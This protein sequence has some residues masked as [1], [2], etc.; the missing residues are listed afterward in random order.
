MH[1]PIML[2]IFPWECFYCA[3]MNSLLAL[4]ENELRMVCTIKQAD[5][6]RWPYWSESQQQQQPIATKQRPRYYVISTSSTIHVE[7][8]NCVIVTS[9]VT[10]R[11]FTACQYFDG[12]SEGTIS[13]VRLFPSTLP[14]FTPLKNYDVVCWIFK[15]REYLLDGRIRP[16]HH[17]VG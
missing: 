13:T 12:V 10:K 17:H 5:C 2:T 4:R 3:S 9:E 11:E 7:I 6:Y 8:S 15:G 14:V 16:G 1:K